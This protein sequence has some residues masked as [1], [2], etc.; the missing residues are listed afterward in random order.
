[1][2][3][4]TQR[5]FVGRSGGSMVV[6]AVVA[7]LMGGCDDGAPDESTTEEAIG[8]WGHG[9]HHRDGVLAGDTLMFHGNRARQG[10]VSAE[11]TLTPEKL[12]GGGFGR[13]W[14][15]PQFAATPNG[16]AP[17]IYSS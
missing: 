11:T 1:M 16:V 17:R 6:A 4:K 7:A 10:W 8:F 15:S 9:P 2:D 5:G 12:R 13:R 14:E 3:V